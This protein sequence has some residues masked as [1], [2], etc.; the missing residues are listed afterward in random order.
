MVSDDPREGSASDR[1]FVSNGVIALGPV[2]FELVL[3]GIAYGRIPAGSFVRHESWQVWRHLED[4]E[5]QSAGH[6]RRTVTELAQHSAELEKRARRAVSV[7]PPPRAAEAGAELSSR[8]ESIAR[9]PRPSFRPAAVDP[10]GVLAHASE[11]PE[12]LL[13]TVVTAVTAAAADFGLV[14]RVRADLGATITVG[15][16]GPSTEHL[17][18]ER[19]AADDPTLVAARAGHSVLSEPQC[20]EVGRYLLGRMTRCSS[21]VSSVAMVPLLV[22][23]E[24]VALFEVGRKSRPF[25]AREIGR[26]EDVVE[27]LAERSVVMGWA[28]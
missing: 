1:W 8:T 19:L 12:A 15:G 10:V 6:R 2:S 22:Y 4:I 18:G 23:G 13:L 5:S 26:V 25:R 3:R 24:L 28:E 14:H 17:L 16:H 9:A 21:E 11:L 20:G 7:P 27:A